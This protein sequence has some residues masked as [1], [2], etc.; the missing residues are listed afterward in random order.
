MKKHLLLIIGFVCSSISFS[1]TKTFT[2]DFSTSNSNIRKLTSVNMGPN[3]VTT[4]GTSTLCYKNIG[5]DMIRAHDYHGPCDYNGYTKFYNSQTKTFDS[6]FNTDL[7]TNYLWSATDTQIDEIVNSGQTPFF[8]LG[9]SYPS[10]GSITP[11]T[12]MPKDADGV[13]F[14]TF[15]GICKKTAMHY[16]DGWDNGSYNYIPYWEVWN[17]PNLALF[18]DLDSVETYYRMYKQVSDSIKAF[19]VNLMIGGPSAAK[20]A[21]YTT[22]S[23]ELVLDH[24]YI[25][26]FFE[27]CKNNDAKLDFYSF[28]SYD[29]KNPYAIRQ[30]AD[31]IQY[32]L[33][34][35]GFTATELMVTETNMDKDN[36]LGYQNSGKGCAFITSTLIAALDTRIKG[37]F[38]YRG[39]DIGLLCN[40]DESGSSNLSLNAYS[41]K[42]F[43]ELSDNTPLRI[44][45]TGDEV[46]T[47]NI[48]DTTLNL[49]LVAGKEITNKEVKV[50]IS[51]LKSNYTDFK[52]DV[53]N[54]PW[55]SSDLITVKV[56][57]LNSSGFLTTTEQI[58]GGSKLTVN[59]SS[60][61]SEST[62]LVTLTRESPNEVLM[63]NFDNKP[64]VFPNPSDDVLNFSENLKNIEIY[65]L[66]GKLIFEKIPF[67]NK[68]STQN[69]Q[70]GVYF[71]KTE[72]S[73]L[74][75]V[76]QH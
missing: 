70:N 55:K 30:L 64:I 17:E 27:Y 13:N 75:F 21:F 46:I 33:D 54:L 52:L 7:S 9:I 24:K 47:N 5:V 8:R 22:K 20:N 32:Y 19:D 16:T 26:N 67:A 28:H 3:N 23:P 37:V 62:Y 11:I 29:R 42:M 39:V 14:K 10:G 4:T 57:K 1:Q 2:V 68:I 66:N 49:M 72:N 48:N 41:Y 63:V 60:I 40:A 44:T 35:S 31:S 12:P 69:L 51:N 53:N 58:N 25:S 18:W 15:A 74:K 65:D 45:T 71:I 59:I 34:L 50:L 38:W 73:N 61:T 36:A 6:N 43:N 56:E 76:V